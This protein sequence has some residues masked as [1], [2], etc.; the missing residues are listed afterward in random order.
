MNKV[1]LLSMVLALIVTVGLFS[2]FSNS[3]VNETQQAIKSTWSHQKSEPKIVEQDKLKPD[4]AVSQQAHNLTFSDKDIADIERWNS[5]SIH[6]PS[7]SGSDY[8][9]YDEET[10]VKLINDGDVMA[11][12]AL[13]SRYLHLGDPSLIE[14]Q[15]ELVERAIIYGDREMFQ[16]MGARAKLTTSLGNPDIT[17]EQRK[18]VALE[19]LALTEFMGMRGQLAR[20]YNDQENLFKL[21]PKIYSSTGKELELTEADKSKVKSRAE[22]IYRYYEQIRMELGLGEF[23]NSVTEGVKKMFHE[24]EKTYL[25]TLGANAIN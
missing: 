10:L 1:I 22:D 23:D 21:Y 12:K 13:W 5:K 11:M 16:F 2:L 6:H 25:K 20:K 24:Q 18:D 9:V 7:F 19:Y 4:G 3:Q 15:Y 8:D 17:E 14:K